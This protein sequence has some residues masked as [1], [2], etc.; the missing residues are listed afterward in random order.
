[1]RHFTNKYGLSFVGVYYAIY[2]A[3]LPAMYGLVK[4]GFTSAE[5]SMQGIK[6]GAESVGSALGLPLAD[7]LDKLNLKPEAAP[8]TMAWTLTKAAKPAR[9]LAAIAITPPVANAVARSLERRGRPPINGSAALKYLVP[10]VVGHFALEMALLSWYV[11]RS[12]GAAE[13]DM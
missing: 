5:G 11:Q 4:S 10:F 2:W 13:R 3:T 8:V 1:M 9:L 7:W 6:A 12:E